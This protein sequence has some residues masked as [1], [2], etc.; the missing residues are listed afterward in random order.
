M[1]ELDGRCAT[2]L[3]TKGAAL[4]LRLLILRSLPALIGDDETYT[5]GG[6]G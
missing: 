3:L 4:G 2:G 1:L 6:T 5:S